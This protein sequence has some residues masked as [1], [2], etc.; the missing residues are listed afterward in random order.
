MLSELFHKPQSIL[1][2]AGAAA[3]PA[4]GRARDPDAEPPRVVPAV[5]GEGAGGDLDRLFPRA[6]RDA[7]GGIA[8]R[9][10][11]A[12]VAA[13]AGFEDGDD[14]EQAPVDV[15]PVGGGDHLV[16]VGQENIGPAGEEL[17]DGVRARI[18]G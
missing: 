5:A 11:P 6:E 13:G 7:A 17:A 12:G 14:G 3:L 2:V 18:W 9:V 15:V 16:G 4:A 10:V 8:E 1:G